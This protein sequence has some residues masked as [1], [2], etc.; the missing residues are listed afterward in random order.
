[1]ADYAAP[2]TE[3]YDSQQQNQT[4]P[5]MTQQNNSHVQGGYQQNRGMRGNRPGDKIFSSKDEDDET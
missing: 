5:N 1:M 3:S 2:G 4:G